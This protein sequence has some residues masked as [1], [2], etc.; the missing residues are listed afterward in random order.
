MNCSDLNHKNQYQKSNTNY[1]SHLIKTLL[2]FNTYISIRYTLNCYIKQNLNINNMC[3]E[4]P[5]FHVHIIRLTRFEGLLFLNETRWNCTFFCID[6]DWL[7]DGH[8][9]SWTKHLSDLLGWVWWEQSLYPYL[10]PSSPTPSSPH[11]TPPDTLYPVSEP[12]HMP[13]WALCYTAKTHLQFT[14]HLL[15]SSLWII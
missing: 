4:L 9:L 6:H 5:S 14:F 13:E 1:Y 3:N 2:I 12:N 11:P 7:G 10:H 8:F 15:T